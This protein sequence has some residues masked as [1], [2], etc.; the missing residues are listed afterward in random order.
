[1]L[2]SFFDRVD[3]AAYRKQVQEQADYLK[4]HPPPSSGAPAAP[5]RPVGRPPKRAAAEVLASAAAAEA[6]I[7]QLPQPK[8]G[9]Y[10]LWFDS[11][12]ISDI[13]VAHARCGGSAR[14]TVE[15]LKATA[16]DNRFEHLSHST[17]I[18]CFR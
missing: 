4:L 6:V 2:S 3:K 7:D 5:K 10:T 11:P 16:P 15:H 12:Y 8:R 17:A 1:M 13:V 14:M 18:S 9:K